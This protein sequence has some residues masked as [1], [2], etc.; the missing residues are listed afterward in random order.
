M[1]GVANVTKQENAIKSHM[2]IV[3]P[4]YSAERSPRPWKLMVFDRLE[5]FSMCARGSGDGSPVYIYVSK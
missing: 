4:H 2:Q 3:P 1:L 5:G